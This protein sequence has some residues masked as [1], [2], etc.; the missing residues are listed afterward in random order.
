VSGSETTTQ[1]GLTGGGSGVTASTDL[2]T[3]VQLTQPATLGTFFDPS[4]V[5]QGQTVQA[6]DSYNTPSAGNLTINWT[7]ANTNVSWGPFSIGPFSPTFSASGPCDILGGGPD[8][9]CDVTSG[10]QTLLDP[11]WPTVGPYAN[12]SMGGVVTITPQGLSTLR[13]TTFSG[14]SGPSAGITLSE[15]P[16][17]DNVVIPCTVAAGDDLNYSL[18]SLSATDGIS[19]DSSLIFDVGAEAPDPIVPFLEDHVQ[20]A[21]PSI[22]F[23]TTTGTISTSGGGTSFDLGDVLANNIHPT[24]NA[25]GPYSSNEGSPITFNGSGS[26]SVCGAPNLVWQFSDGGIAYGATPQHTFESPGTFSGSLTATDVTGLSSTTTFS[27]TVADLPPVVSAGPNMSS[28]W[29]FPVTLNGSAI[30]PGTAQQ[31][32]LTYSWAFGDGTG[33]SGGA[34][35]T[36]TYAT[37][38]TYTATLTVCDP[39]DMCGSS[40]TTVTINKRGTVVSYTGATTS[41]VTVPSTLTATLL[42]AYGNPVV[43]RVVQFFIQGSLTPFA[44]ATT[45]TS[46]TVTL[47]YAFPFGTVGTNTVVA[48]FAGD[49]LYSTSQFSFPYVVTP[50]PLTVTAVSASRPY[51]AP[52]PLGA[53]ISGFVGGQTLATSGITGAANCTTTATA[54]SNPGTYPITCTIGSLASPNYASTTFVPGTLTVTKAP[55]TVVAANTTVVSGLLSRTVTMTATLTSNVTGTGLAGQSISFA[56][57][58]SIA[59]GCSATTNSSGVASCSV[60]LNLLSNDP[61]SYAASYAGSTDYLSSSGGA[62]VKP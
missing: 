18:G 4:Q 5:R 48:K 3:N 16:I 56:A 60:Q 12:L 39:E 13:S 41:E 43:G 50:A 30:D 15:A 9:T 6:N 8:Y 17:T 62:T 2:I 57:N 53:T 61:T 26:T 47:S 29:G 36:H 23:G 7:L 21:S 34:S 51:G 46:G 38:G 11:G 24:V 25:G 1:N 55:T 37:P 54:T 22:D 44:S 28:D 52:N 42:D 20:F 59:A 58:S 27:V 35:V 31:P 14:G 40:P 45:P 10:Q 33:G 19:V 32:Y 49:S